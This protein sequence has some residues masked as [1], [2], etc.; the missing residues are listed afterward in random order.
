[1]GYS[2]SDAINA[3][4]DKKLSKYDFFKQ[5][6]TGF[7]DSKTL[8]IERY[9]KRSGEGGRGTR[10]YL[11]A[12]LNLLFN[13]TIISAFFGKP[14]IVSEIVKDSKHRKRHMDEIMRLLGGR[15]KIGKI[16]FDSE[17]LTDFF[18]FMDSERPLIQEKI[19]NPFIELP[20]F[21]VAGK[22]R[23]ISVYEAYKAGGTEKTEA[24]QMLLAYFDR[25]IEHAYRL[26][27]E[28][29]DLVGY[30]AQA[31]NQIMK[32]YADAVRFDDLLDDFRN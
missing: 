8:I 18:N 9:S 4:F 11:K 16:Q 2:R 29:K 31:Q 32:D 19:P 13:V 20:Q 5:R 14:A 6:L 7:E 12:H 1:M 15:L 21:M 24:E 10:V 22:E 17:K 30:N 3:L 23:Y 28:L 25:D 26:A 27:S